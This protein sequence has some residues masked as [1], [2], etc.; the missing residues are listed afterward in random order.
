[1][2]RKELL[3][4]YGILPVGHKTVALID[5]EDMPAA[6]RSAWKLKTNRYRPIAWTKCERTGKVYYLHHSVCARAHGPRPSPEH[7]C[8]ALNGDS[9][10]CRSK[11]LRWVLKNE[12]TYRLAQRDAR[13]RATA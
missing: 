8:E 12:T 13:E 5:I 3:S 2:D 6:T 9:L 4:A 11:N 7:V 10:D 1:M